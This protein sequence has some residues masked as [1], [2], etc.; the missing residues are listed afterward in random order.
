MTLETCAFGKRF[1]YFAARLHTS[2]HRDRHGA[3]V[4]TSRCQRMGLC[5][6]DEGHEGARAQ[7]PGHVCYLYNTN[8]VRP[9]DCPD[10]GGSCCLG[11]GQVCIPGPI[12]SAPQSRPK[13]T[14]VDC[15]TDLE[16][17]IGAISRP[18]H[19]LALVH[20]PVDQEIR[21]AFGDRRPD[22]LTGS[23]PS[24]GPKCALSYY[25]QGG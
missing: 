22:P 19:L 9:W 18:S 10:I 12:K 3:T 2:P 25:V 23:D 24:A 8:I 17:Q 16:Q 11:N 4:M 21:C 7:C 6:I 5:C 14:V 20:A 13:R 15:T 1:G